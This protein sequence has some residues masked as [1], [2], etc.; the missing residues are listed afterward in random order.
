MEAEQGS[1]R[2]HSRMK[3]EGGEWVGGWRLSRG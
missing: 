2:L 3:E 1:G